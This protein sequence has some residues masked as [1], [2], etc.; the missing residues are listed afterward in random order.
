LMALAAIEL[1]PSRRPVCLMTIEASS[2]V[3]PA[4]VSM[5]IEAQGYR[6]LE[7]VLLMA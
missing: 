6:P 3:R 4:V 1:R 7:L 5:A 2:R